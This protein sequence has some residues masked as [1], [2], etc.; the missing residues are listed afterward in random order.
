MLLSLDKHQD[1]I[2]ERVERCRIARQFREPDRVPVAFGIGGSYYSWLQ[3]VNIRDYYTTPELQVDVQLGG[4]Q[5]QVEFLKADSSV[6][7]SIA[8]DGGPVG[9]AIVFDAEVVYP[10]NTSPRIVHCCETLEDALVIEPLPPESNPRLDALV[11]QRQQFADA[12]D[13]MGVRIAH[14][15]SPGIGIHPPLSCLCALIKRGVEFGRLHF[16]GRLG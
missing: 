6:A 1:A 9:E 11:A 12:A 7:Q 15:V 10:D 16:G 14:P 2:R 8:F 13:K 4:L 5:W 3:G